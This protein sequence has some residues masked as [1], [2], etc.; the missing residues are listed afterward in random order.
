MF[1]QIVGVPS[2]SRRDFLDRERHL[3]NSSQRLR[4]PTRQHRTRT[5]VMAVPAHNPSSHRVLICLRIFAG[6]SIACR[7]VPS[8]ATWLGSKMVA[9]CSVFVRC[10][11]FCG[12]AQ[13][14]GSCSH[15]P[16]RS[17]QATGVC[18]IVF[19]GQPYRELNSLSLRQHEQKR[20]LDVILL[21]ASPRQ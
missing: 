19:P 9:G 11:Y 5:S 16:G 18:G 6:L 4:R 3:H 15:L 1:S 14:N 10:H 8:A 7:S 17:P 12:E 20:I 2:V 21:A 13:R